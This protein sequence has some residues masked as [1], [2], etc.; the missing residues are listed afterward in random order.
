MD[1]LGV[2]MD[3]RIIFKVFFLCVSLTKIKSSPVVENPLPLELKIYKD[4]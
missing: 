1:F 2:F 3:Q 4:C